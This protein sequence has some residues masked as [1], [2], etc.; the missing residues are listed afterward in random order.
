MQ[1]KCAILWHVGS[2]TGRTLLGSRLELRVYRVTNLVCAV[3]IEVCDSPLDFESLKQ[4]VS[5]Q[6]L[7]GAAFKTLTE[8]NAE[9]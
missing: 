2:R 4:S 8:L 6:T 1:G 9:I 3:L 7:N 5:W